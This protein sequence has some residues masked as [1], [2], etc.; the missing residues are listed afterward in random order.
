MTYQRI[1]QKDEDDMRLDRF[2]KK[3]FPQA[4]SWNIYKLLRLK[5]IRV[6]NIRAKEDT[7][8]FEG[9]T[10]EIFHNHEEL[11]LWSTPQ[12][13]ASDTRPGVLRELPQ[14]L[15]EDEWMLAV[16]KPPF[17]SVHP[18]DHKTD[19]ASLIEILEDFYRE[20]WIEVKL[21]H[22]IDRETSWVVLLGKGRRATQ[23]LLEILQ[24]N[25]IQKIYH[26]IVSGTARRQ[27]IDVPLLRQDGVASQSKVI[28]SKD[29]QRA[30]THIRPLN[31]W[32]DWTRLEC[33]I[34]TGRMHQIR[35]HC[36][37]ICHPIFGDK[38]Y[39]GSEQ[40]RAKRQLLHAYSLQFIHPFTRKTLEI[41]APYFPDFLPYEGRKL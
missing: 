1:V 5:K 34:E 36:A 38:R 31:I 29:W 2:L 40:Y 6:A 33:Q 4:S 30:I 8:I 13:Q 17:L 22:R 28:V 27:T 19:E 37:H 9:Q 18:W 3:L 32:E 24:S 11:E 41:I 25:Q 20:K 12:V 26:A 10:I 23:S 16:N 39:A 7:R 15:Y 21:I 35:V 14:I